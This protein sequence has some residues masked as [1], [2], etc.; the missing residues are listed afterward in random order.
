V[1]GE[2]LLDDISLAVHAFFADFCPRPVHLAVDT[3]LHED[4]IDARAYTTQPNSLTKKC[5]RRL[6]ARP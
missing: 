4:R 2:Q 1:T 5:V 6:G 3:R